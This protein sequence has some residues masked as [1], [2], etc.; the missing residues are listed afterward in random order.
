MNH[1]I[2]CAGGTVPKILKGFTKSSM[3]CEK[4][5]LSQCLEENTTIFPA[6]PQSTAAV[7][8]I[9][10]FI[11]KLA[12]PLTSFSLCLL[13]RS[14]SSPSSNALF[15]GPVRCSFLCPPRPQSPHQSRRR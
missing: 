6:Y 5:T 1:L 11:Q 9:G 4:R 10:E 8:W 7:V 3:S 12:G 13:Y 14:E 2:A 15:L